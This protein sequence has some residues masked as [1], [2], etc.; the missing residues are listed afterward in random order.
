LF[1]SRFHPAVRGGCFL[2]RIALEKRSCRSLVKSIA[3]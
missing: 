2:V 1:V 3:D